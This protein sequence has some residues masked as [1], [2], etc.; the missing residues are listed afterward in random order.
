MGYMRGY[1]GRYRKGLG[2][3]VRGLGI[4]KK[5][6]EVYQAPVLKKSFLKEAAILKRK[7]E[8]HLLRKRLQ[9]TLIFTFF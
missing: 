6:K 2:Y 1:M 3:I 5:K 7:K 9:I 8:L 4:G